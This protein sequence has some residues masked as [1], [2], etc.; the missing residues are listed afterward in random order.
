VYLVDQQVD[1]RGKKWYA[2][3]AWKSKTLLNNAI[4]IPPN[5]DRIVYLADPYFPE[6]NEDLKSMNLRAIPVY[7]NY[8]IYFQELPASNQRN[9]SLP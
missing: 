2:F 1:V 7:E 5:V 9:D 8:A 3:G 6:S 4:R